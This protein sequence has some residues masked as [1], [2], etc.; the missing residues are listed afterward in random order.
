MANKREEAI[1]YIATSQ[2]T[3]K[4]LGSRHVEQRAEYRE[5]LDERFIV[6]RI[7]TLL[8]IPEVAE[9]IMY[10]IRYGE[11]FIIEDSAMGYDVVVAHH[12]DKVDSYPTL[13]AI[14]MRSQ[15]RFGD[16]QKILS[17]YKDKVELA[18]WNL[19]AKKK[20]VFEW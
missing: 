14:T 17:V 12:F 3:Y 18:V 2:D 6:G 4:V 11:T 9:A 15:L 8:S 5:A 20:E 19:A 16:G 1:A 7:G 10:G 13:T